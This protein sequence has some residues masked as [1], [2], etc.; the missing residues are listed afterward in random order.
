M[1]VCVY[2]VYCWA[3]GRKSV[4]ESE[5][6]IIARSE[7]RAIEMARVRYGWWGREITAVLIS[8]REISDAG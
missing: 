7:T 8:E 4:V 3:T 1:K 5:G 2:K 6:A